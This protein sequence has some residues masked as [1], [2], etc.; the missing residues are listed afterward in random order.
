MRPRL[1]TVEVEVREWFDVSTTFVE[2]SIAS[3][4]ARSVLLLEKQ[5]SL[6]ISLI[7]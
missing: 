5:T 4:L 2:V 7:T 6:V 3:Q 1:P